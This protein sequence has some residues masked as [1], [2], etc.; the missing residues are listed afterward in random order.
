[1]AFSQYNRLRIELGLG[2]SAF[3]VSLKLSVRRE[4]MLTDCCTCDRLDTVC[5]PT[6]R[7]WQSMRYCL[8]LLFVGYD[9]SILSSFYVRSSR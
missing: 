7:V 9:L 3:Y 2:S 6:Y 1:M 4:S 8:I 5:L